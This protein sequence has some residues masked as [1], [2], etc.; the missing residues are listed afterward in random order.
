MTTR[1]F[2]ALASSTLAVLLA[3][4]ANPPQSGA[5]WHSI[6][7]TRSASAP[8]TV[9]PPIGRSVRCTLI[10]DPTPG[11][12]VRGP[13]PAGA[14][15]RGPAQEVSPALSGHGENGGYSPADLRSAYDLPGGNAGVGQTVA[16]VEAYNDPDAEADLA[17]YR[18]VERLSS[19]GAEGECLRRVNQRGGTSLPA[20]NSKWAEETSFDLDMVSAICP[21]CHILV[22]EAENA[23]SQNIAIA[24]D[25]AVAL[26]AT[27]ISDSF[28]Q[29]TPLEAQEAAAYDHPGIPIAVAAGDNDYGVV[30]PAANPNV[31]AVGGTTLEPSAG[32]GG[33]IETAWSKTGGGCSTEAKPAWQTDTCAGRTTN[34]V[35]AVADPNS[36]VSAYD[37]Y[38]T[39][40][41]PWLL[42]GGTSV[43]APIV[44]AAMALA[45]PYTRSFDGAHGLYLEQANGID[46]F[47]DVLTGSTGSCHTYLCEAGTGYDGP[48][49][50]GGLRGAPE[51]PPPAAATGGASAAASG[52]A[53]LKG[54]VN[55]H[56]V[57]LTTCTL[58]YRQSPGHAWTTKPCSPSPAA[59]VTPVEVSATLAGLTPGT[60]YEYQAAA[61]YPGGSAEAEGEVLSF[62]V[63]ST[64]P[65]VFSQS[66][67]SLTQTSEALGAIINPGGA[68]V[69][70]C[71]FEYGQSSPG[72]GSFAYC[73]TRPGT[74]NSPVAVSAA[75][76]ALQPN[77]TY[78]FRVYIRT[79]TG[80]GHEVHG[81]DE[82][83]T[84]PPL[85]PTPTTLPASAVASGSATLNATVDPHGAA[86]TSCEFEFASGTGLVPC[87]PGPGSGES[88]VAVSASVAGLS[89][90]TRYL[91]RVLAANAGGVAYGEIGELTTA[92]ASSDSGNPEVPPVSTPPLTEDPLGGS[93]TQ[94]V[95]SAGASAPACATHL[96]S[97][98]LYA[99]A[100][101][102]VK[103]TLLCAREG[104]ERH[105]T[106]TLLMSASTGSGSRSS[107]Q[108]S[109]ALATA[110]FAL[111]AGGAATVV[112]HLSG[113]ARRLLAAAHL[114]HARA[115]IV[116]KP[117]LAAAASTA[118]VTLRPRTT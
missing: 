8:F 110:S 14:I 25:E 79:A 60:A 34:D 98:S 46:G 17:E 61:S 4:A 66:A 107:S 116:T 42:A 40:G 49:G 5:W 57:S 50:L 13:V 108:T 30:W 103:L 9:C 109:T 102:A 115:L 78:H 39:H 33:W 65:S 91:Y 64:Q 15:T 70:E 62:T 35:A 20:P 52:E 37:S 101:G 77:T 29:S 32:R 74:G 47:Y 105:G 19:C 44:A 82:T 12:R 75:A 99:S 90:S 88:P 113:R 84:T 53:T 81:E 2:A 72:Y 24:E 21:N 45:S 43:A 38:E 86:V 100:S 26:H 104:A 11:S 95:T 87:S 3:A 58:R 97:R 106:V 6:S 96:A 1:R 23:E 18:K 54:T 68:S 118:S 73:P 114:L 117:P 51:V 27:E 71:W 63:P 36:P 10:E 67:S 76:S 41:S 55:P 28:A 111:P 89:P 56:G 48:S 92:A 31:I 22:V 7:P 93:P 85:A 16:V 80:P 112:L 83:F 59:V 94:V 69:E